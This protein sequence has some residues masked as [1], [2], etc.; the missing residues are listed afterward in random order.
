[1]YQHF[2][3]PDPYIARSGHLRAAVAERTIEGTPTFLRGLRVLFAS[4][5]HVLP[6]TTRADLDALARRFSDIGPDLLL[7]GGDYSDRAEGTHRLF[8]ALAGVKPPLG[9]FGVVGNND[10]EAWAERVGELRSV[11]AKGGC[12]LLLNEAVDIPYGGGTIRLAGIDEHLHGK[13]SI[14][15]LYPAGPREDNYRILLSHYPVMPVA[16]P[17]MMLCGHTHGGQFNLLGLTP[18]GIGFE[19]LS[20][21][22]PHAVAVSGLLTVEG[23]RLLVS[24]GIGASRIQWRVGVRPE[25]ELLTF[26]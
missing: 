25:I 16:R 1:M 4:D 21:H 23:M 3:R 10:A 5:M 14:S 13:P 7:L 17:D 12:R 18:Y 2:L 20:P 15:R 8:E 24:K 6:R 26:R 11:M 22:R 19:R 9:C